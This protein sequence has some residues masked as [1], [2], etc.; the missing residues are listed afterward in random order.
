M[1]VPAH[2]ALNQD[3]LTRVLAKA[4][5]GDLVTLGA[6][7]LDATYLPMLYDPASG[8][9]IG[10]LAR[11]NRQSRDNGPALF[12]VHG[13]DDFIEADW[14]RTPA[15]DSVPTWNYVT[16][17][18]RGDLVAH[19]DPEWTLD[20]VRRLSAAHGDASVDAM[21]ADGVEKLL[22]AIVGVELRNLRLEG[23]AKMSQNKSPQVVGQVIDGLR[24]SGRAETAAW[25]T[26]YSLPRAL[27]K[28]EL[29]DGIR[30]RHS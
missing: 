26:E 4:P 14:L 27:A 19:D 18:A 28:A 12:I 7:G 17:H 1:Y 29:L 24:A 20:V 23:K 11:V 2:F 6:D 9:L 13:P 22:R 25:M 3:Q 16:V 10:H 21:P 15:A 5:A 8:S 30:E